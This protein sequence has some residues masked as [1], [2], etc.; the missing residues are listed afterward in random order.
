MLLTKTLMMTDRDSERASLMKSN[1]RKETKLQR[2][3]L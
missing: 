2:K 3:I 1:T